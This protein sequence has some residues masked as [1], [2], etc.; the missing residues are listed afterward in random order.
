MYE[1]D[2]VVLH[3]YEIKLLLPLFWVGNKLFRSL[4]L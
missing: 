3:K 2:I 4:I 1:Y